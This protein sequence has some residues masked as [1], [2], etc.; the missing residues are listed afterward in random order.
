MQNA[1]VQTEVEFFKLSQWNL[2]NS[3]SATG[4]LKADG[5]FTVGYAHLYV[6]VQHPYLIN[7]ARR[8]AWTT[9]AVINPRDGS[10]T[11]KDPSLGVAVKNAFS[12]A[13]R[14][15]EVRDGEFR[16]GVEYRVTHEDANTKNCEWESWIKTTVK[17]HD[18]DA[19]RAFCNT[20]RGWW[21]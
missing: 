8:Y 1:T 15:L 12:D 7:E 18:K 10:V 21:P 14:C 4:Y 2:W 3:I 20:V 19:M 11:L 17:I 6:D 9:T 5:S 16:R 13:C